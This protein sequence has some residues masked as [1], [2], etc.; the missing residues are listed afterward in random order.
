MKFEICA[1]QAIGGRSSQQDAWKVAD[2]GGALLDAVGGKGKALIEDRALVLVADGVAEGDNSDIASNLACD[3]FLKEFFGSKDKIKDRM[4]TALRIAHEAVFAKRTSDP[5]LDKIATTLIGVWLE[6]DRMTFVSVGDSL[7]LR[8]RDDEIHLVNLD[9]SYY[10]V[11]DRW[12]LEQFEKGGGQQV[13]DNAYAS[14]GQRASITLALGV[15]ISDSHLQHHQQVDERPIQPGDILIVASDGLET[16]K[17]P[18]I[19]HIVRFR[20]AGG[21]EAVATS[22]MSAVLGTAEATQ[23]RQDNTTLVV[24]RAVGEETRKLA[25][26]FIPATRKVTLA[27]AA[28]ALIVAVGSIALHFSATPG[29]GAGNRGAS[30]PAAES[31]TSFT[32]TFRGV[33][34]QDPAITA[35]PNFNAPAPANP[36]FGAPAPAGTPWPAQQPGN[37]AGGYPRNAAPTAPSEQRQATPQPWPDPRA[38]IPYQPMRSAS[39]PVWPQPPRP[40]TPCRISY[41]QVYENN[42]Y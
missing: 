8:F 24:I 25:G 28:L 41:P 42:C 15:Q 26:G 7:L 17:Y 14:P 40:D 4:K 5:R 38:R 21:A 6:G 32:D 34:P 31:T 18:Q 9:H 27:A 19:Q 3:T 16:L 36:N 30:R 22:L 1:R 20:A 29:P 2:G 12:S 33:P 13:W 23:R 11:L 35:N 39:D 10:E 37:P